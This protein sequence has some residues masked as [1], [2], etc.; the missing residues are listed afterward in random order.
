[1]VAYELY[2]YDKLNG[3]E[4]IGILPERRKDPKRITKESVLKWGRMVLGDGADN[5]NIIFTQITMDDTTR[6]ISK[7][8]SEMA[9]PLFI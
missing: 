5:Y 8:G 3:Y 1:M 9:L 2:V 7:A 6:Q 4:L